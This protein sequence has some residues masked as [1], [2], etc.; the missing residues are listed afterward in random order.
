[1]YFEDVFYIY[2]E[3]QA[4]HIPVFKCSQDSEFHRRKI[5][6]IVKII[7]L[8]IILA[9]TSFHTCDATEVLYFYKIMCG[10]L[11]DFHKMYNISDGLFSDNRKCICVPRE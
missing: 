1:M 8:L 3:N 6:I 9:K 7:V 11:L 2:Q 5:I 4:Q 10:V